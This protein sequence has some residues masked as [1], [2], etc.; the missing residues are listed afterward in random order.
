MTPLAGSI[1]VAAASAASKPAA[2][3]D[4]KAPTEPVRVVTVSPD[5]TPAVALDRRNVEDPKRLYTTAGTVRGLT[6]AA[7]PEDRDDATARFAPESQDANVPES[8]PQGV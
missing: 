1:A 6:F 8:S 5:E 3:Q 2:V 7:S 4:A